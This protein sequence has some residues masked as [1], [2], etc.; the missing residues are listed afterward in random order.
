MTATAGDEFELG[1]DE[2]IKGDVDAVKAC[3]E[4]VVEVAGEENAVGGEGKA[5]GGV[6]KGEALNER[7]EVLAKEWLTACKANFV[8]ATADEERG[9]AEKFGIGEQM[10]RGG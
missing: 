9:E 2:S 3:C 5:R 6:E 7:D 10:W 1:L 4:E 8:D